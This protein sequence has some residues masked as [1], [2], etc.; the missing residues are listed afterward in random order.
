MTRLANTLRIS[1]ALSVALSA[2]IALA[3]GL[4]GCA[5]RPS[6]NAEEATVELKNVNAGAPQQG[7]ETFASPQEAAAVFK[8]AVITKDRRH[9]IQ[10]F[11]PSGEQ[12]VL[13]GDRVQE[14]NDLTAFGGHLAENLRVDQE[15]ADKAVLYVG[16]NN[17]P[18]PIPLVRSGSQW[19]FDTAA[20]KEELLDRRIGENELSTIEVCKAY[21][22]AQ[23][24]Y[25][26]KDRNGDGVS[27]YAQKFRSTPGKKD[28]LYWEAEANEEISPMGPLVAGAREEG[29]G[30]QKQTGNPHPYHGYYFHILTGQGKD[31]PGGET[32]Y[33]KDGRMVK[34]FALVAW[35]S[36][37]DSSGVMTFLV[38]QDGKV[39]QKDLG[40]NTADVASQMKEYDPDSSWK[41]VKGE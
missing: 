11:G 25:A 9:L 41:E 24:E 32:S 15:G 39:Y 10:I 4:A 33:I 34:G 19:F 29:Y 27:Q 18:F 31:A 5:A 38:N 12:L 1:G 40:E 37:Y 22:A 14:N 13:S 16:A 35:P 2:A 36:Q 6:Q 17:W 21:V 8:E 3:W 30:G 26:Q 28:G 23:K 20:G 7:Q